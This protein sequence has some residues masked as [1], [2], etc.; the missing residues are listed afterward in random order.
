MYLSP[1][2]LATYSNK[3]SLLTHQSFFDHLSSASSLENKI[4]T[5]FQFPNLKAL[6]LNLLSIIFQ[7]F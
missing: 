7:V 6:I 4:T 5:H 3:Y 1:I 2:P